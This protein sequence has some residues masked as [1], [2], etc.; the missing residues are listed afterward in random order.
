MYV[1]DKEAVDILNL[2]EDKYTVI[3]DRTYYDYV[4][5]AQK[6]QT[7]SG[8]KYHKKRIITMHFVGNM[9]EDMNL[10]C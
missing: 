1:V 4:Y 2:P 6:L 3:P 10:N 9:K 7:L 8:R 5:D